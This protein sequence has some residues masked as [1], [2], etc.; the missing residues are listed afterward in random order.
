MAYQLKFKQ[1]SESWGTNKYTNKKTDMDI[2]K[3]LIL[4]RLRGRQSEG[5][6]WCVKDVIPY[7]IMLSK[8]REIRR[9]LSCAI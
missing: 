8:Q 9:D 1:I 7:F 5:T 3:K 6:L 2:Q 4:F